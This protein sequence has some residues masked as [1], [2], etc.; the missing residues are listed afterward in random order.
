MKTLIVLLVFVC[1]TGCDSTGPKDVIPDPDAVLST[2]L[3]G[4]ITVYWRDVSN[5]ETKYEVEYSTDAV[6]WK[7]LKELPANSTSAQHSGI[8]YQVTYFYRVRACRITECSN[9]VQTSTKWAS[10]EAPNLSTPFVT[11]ISTNYATVAVSATHGGLR[12]EVVIYLYI[13]D[14]V[15]YQSPTFEVEASSDPTR[16]GRM[17]NLTM[18]GLLEGTDYKLLVVAKNAVGITPSEEVKFKTSKFGPPSVSFLGSFGPAG[19]NPVDRTW[20]SLPQAI[21]DPGGMRTEVYA[22]VVEA[23]RSFALARRVPPTPAVISTNVVT[24]YT[25]TIS[26]LQPATAYKW[27]LTATNAAGTSVSDS[28][29]FTTPGA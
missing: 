10:G 26:G 1:L 19:F 12:T 4:S 11:G 7:L 15:V 23:E 20:T 2:A 3:A 21:V 6:S 13:E 16:S 29:V 5:L 9:W 24:R 14:K 27:R 25:S 28:V 8:E 22:E 17:I 18:F